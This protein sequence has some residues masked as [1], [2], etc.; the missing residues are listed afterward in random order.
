MKLILTIC[1]SLSATC[2][3]FAQTT[4]K[5]DTT[6][7]LGILRKMLKPSASGPGKH[8]TIALL[9]ALGYNPSIGFQM[10]LNV[11]GGMYFGNKDSNILSIFT[12]SAFV[13]T[14]QIATGQLRHNIFIHNNEW[15]FQGNWQVSRI[16]TLDYGE[17]TGITKGT[18]GHF[19]INDLPLENDSAVFPIKFTYYRFT[20]RAYR[21]IAPHWYA[22]AG[23][24]LDIRNN[25]D[26]QKLDSPAMTPHSRY[27]QA[28]GFNP[29]HYSANGLLFDILY[30][31]KEHPNRSYGGMYADAGLRINQQWLGSTKNSFQLL[32]EFR[33][34]WSLSN[35]NPEHVLAVWAWGSFLLAGSIPYLELPGTA[36]DVY[37]RSGRGYTSGRFKGLSFFCE[38]TEYRFPITRNKLMSGAV[39]MN[40]QTGSNQQGS[41]LFEYWEPAAGAGLRF[42]FNR[43]TRTNLC[44][45]FALGR[46]G[47]KGIFF[48][49]NEVF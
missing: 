25:I 22:G 46:Y 9:P 3:L 42:L 41:S 6:D 11:S 37:N 33:K 14:K 35:K 45:D 4:P 27:S 1:L 16:A 23:L 7:L 2:W 5:V 17:G 34:Y 26:D 31:T 10:G 15:N 30:N 21:T 49:L 48:G 40:L 43:Y 13:T 28:N 24:S 12:V 20:E 36:S 8:S 39:F 38:E 18:R 47:S 32:T 29:K 44:I 19:S